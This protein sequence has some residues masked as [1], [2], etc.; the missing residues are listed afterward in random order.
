MNDNEWMNCKLEMW[1]K[2]D[3]DDDFIWR[4]HYAVILVLVNWWRKSVTQ[5]W[6]RD[7]KAR[8]QDAHLPRPRLGVKITRRDW[9]ET[10]VAIETL[11]YK[12]LPCCMQCR[13]ERWESC[14]SVHQT[15]ELWQNG[16]KICQDFYT[17]RKTI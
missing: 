4:M 9:D 11:K 2:R 5:G 1:N 7:V 12:F 3:D 13:R 6:A 17:I 8:D 16:R 10:F 15:R 14:L